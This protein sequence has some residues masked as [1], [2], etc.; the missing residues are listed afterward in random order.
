MSSVAQSKKIVR[1]CNT[2]KVQSCPDGF[3]ET[4]LESLT[5]LMTKLVTSLHTEPK[6]RKNSPPPF[7]STSTD[8]AD[9]LYPLP[10]D[11][12]PPPKT[13]GFSEQLKS[14]N[15]YGCELDN[16]LSSF[17]QAV[18][19]II[20]DKNL[21]HTQHGKD[22]DIANANNIYN[23]NAAVNHIASY[24]SNPHFVSRPAYLE[25]AS[26]LESAV[27]KRLIES[28]GFFST[29]QIKYYPAIIDY[30]SEDLAWVES[31]AAVL[32][33]ALH[34]Q[35]HTSLQNTGFSAFN[36]SPPVV[37]VSAASTREIYWL[38][39]VVLER[40]YVPKSC[41]SLVPC[42]ANTD[43][44][45]TDKFLTILQND[46]KSGKT[47]A[48]VILKTGTPDS[49]SIED[50]KSVIRM[51]DS[52]GLWVHC[53]GPALSLLFPTPPQRFPPPS[54]LLTASLADSVSISLGETFG[55]GVRGLPITTFFRSSPSPTD[56]FQSANVPA[57]IFCTL[58][59]WVWFQHLGLDRISHSI[60]DA[61][62]KTQRL[63]KSLDKCSAV[64]LYHSRESSGYAVLFRYTT[65]EDDTTNEIVEEEPEIL[66]DDD[67]AVVNCVTRKIF[68]LIETESIAFSL[69]Q[70]GGIDYIK[71][72]ILNQASSITVAQIDECAQKIA[73]ECELYD[74]LLKLKSGN[75]FEDVLKEFKE[76]QNIALRGKCIKDEA[77][78]L[79]GFRYIPSYLRPLSTIDLHPTIVR[80]IDELNHHLGESLCTEY[81][82]KLFD[83]MVDITGAVGT[84]EELAVWISVGVDRTPFDR[85]HLRALLTSVSVIA[86]KLEQSPTLT[87]ILSSLI[88]SGIQSA[89]EQLSKQNSPSVTDSLLTVASP[90]VYGL[91]TLK[92]VPVLGGLLSWV[93]GMG[94]GNSGTSNGTEA[95]VDSEKKMGV[96]FCLGDAQ[97]KSSPF[98]A[99]P[100]SRNP[101][102]ILWDITK[103]ASTSSPIE[104]ELTVKQSDVETPALQGQ[105][106]HV[107]ELKISPEAKVNK[108]N[109]WETESK[110]DII[111]DNEIEAEGT[112]AR[113]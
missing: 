62:D 38:E 72:N 24:L 54:T 6:S 50:L 9:T 21:T 61:I 103:P 39:N 96:R 15:D 18:K 104:D 13:F 31:I 49:Q 33:S 90:V 107:N 64:H 16:V 69:V 108:E 87:S 97:L 58:P 48:L 45:D 89:E 73:T 110:L 8:S 70:L 111:I 1:L 7:L 44:M 78:K 10:D 19:V 92:A 35:Y 28:F 22:V 2:D 4:D 86:S 100:Q 83:V 3:R 20:D 81:N 84:E 106:E 12:L 82:G 75:G 37:Y 36:D 74:S 14:F 56:W 85:S 98:I 60:T 5:T 32:R 79:G 46:I 26:L 43:V 99:H 47:P 76:F 53:E 40:N 63:S 112:K 11:V 34:K 80:L 25:I 105:N 67:R 68:E 101:T 65:T 42:F 88:V 95:V 27:R 23:T 52:V 29:K 51:A 102:P 66:R 41:L 59:I 91:N 93:P 94:G 77:V 71:F 55:L 113:N 17:S 57:S 109:E 30:N